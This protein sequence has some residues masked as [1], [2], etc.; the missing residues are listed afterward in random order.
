MI[1]KWGRYCW[2]TLLFSFLFVIIVIS[3]IV[4]WCCCFLFYVIDLA[5]VAAAASPIM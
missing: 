2:K 4:V 3:N 1:N 5:P